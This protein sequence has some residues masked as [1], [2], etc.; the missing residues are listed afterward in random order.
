MLSP[1]LDVVVLFESSSF[2][3]SC[4]SADIKSFE[5]YPILSFTFTLFQTESTS[6]KTITSVFIFNF[7][8]MLESVDGSFLKL[9]LLNFI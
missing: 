5:T 8:I 2:D 6:S 3:S 9:T 1:S 4:F 7:Y